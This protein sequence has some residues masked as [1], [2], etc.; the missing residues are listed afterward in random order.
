MDARAGSTDAAPH[1]ASHVEVQHDA[2]GDHHHLIEDSLE[3][4]E[5]TS[6]D[7]GGSR[8]REL[9]GGDYE[10]DDDDD[11]STYGGASGSKDDAKDGKIGRGGKRA[12]RHNWQPKYVMEFG[13][14]AIEKDQAA[15]DVTLAMCGFCK[16]F[17][18]EGKYEQLLQAEAEAAAAAA[19]SSTESK[20]RRRRSLTT[21]KFFRAFRVD[22]IRS[23]LQGAHPRRW[24][25]FEMLP[26]Q[27]APR[28]RY[29][30]MQGDLHYES[31]HM[32]DDVVSLNTE[33]DMAYA[34][35]QVQALAHP[36]IPEE[37]PHQPTTTV[38]S[39]ATTTAVVA[40]TA[41]SAGLNGSHAPAQ[42]APA[43]QAYMG[44]PFCAVD[45]SP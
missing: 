36:V 30:Q 6:S 5:D 27:E 34:Q 40:A 32:V 7:L 15:G 13:L 43:A 38:T 9:D 4:Y 23:H 19:S 17:G 35:A 20:K 41:N 8:K 22:N 12:R 44:E 10:D 14:I 37:Q 31:L 21:T 16:A 28:A 29:L 2:T 1:D 39:A 26:K 3:K 25:E 11:A 42:T 45:R 18:R 33:S 24:A